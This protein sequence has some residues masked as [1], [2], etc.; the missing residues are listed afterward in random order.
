MRGSITSVN[1][2]VLCDIR[3]VIVPVELVVPAAMEEENVLSVG[4]EVVVS[5][6][7]RT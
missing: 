6:F 3:N 5:D 2:L 7:K 4:E 1:E